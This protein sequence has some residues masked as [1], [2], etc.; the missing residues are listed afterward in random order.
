MLTLIFEIN[1][2]F[3][4][5][6][7]YFFVGMIFNRDNKIKK[8][9]SERKSITRKFFEFVYLFVFIIT[10]LFFKVQISYPLQTGIGKNPPPA[11]ANLV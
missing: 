10:K 8:S 3:N 6:C 4:N 2:F 5:F 1:V 9:T 7:K 11:T